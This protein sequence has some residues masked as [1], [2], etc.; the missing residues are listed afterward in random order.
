LE[1]TEQLFLF[2]LG[3]IVGIWIEP[4]GLPWNMGSTILVFVERGLFVM[5]LAVVGFG[6]KDTILDAIINHGMS[7]LEAIVVGVLH[8]RIDLLIIDRPNKINSRRKG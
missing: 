2:S 1:K 6:S 7:C 3:G 5:M 4:C 8:G